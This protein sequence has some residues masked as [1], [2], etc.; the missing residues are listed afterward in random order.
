MVIIFKQGLKTA[1]SFWVGSEV[2]GRNPDIFLTYD[3]SVDFKTRCDELI[4]WFK[5][6]DLDFATLYYNEPD[7]TGHTYGPDA[8]EY[9]DKV[10]YFLFHFLLI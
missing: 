1:S 2:W 8:N 10:F 6:F 7:S 9:Y 4:H 3:G 5:V